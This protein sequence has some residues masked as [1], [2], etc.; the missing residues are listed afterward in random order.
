VILHPLE[1]DQA[2]LR[3]SNLVVQYLELIGD[4]EARYLGV[5]QLLDRLPD[6]LLNLT[7]AN[8]VGLG[9]YGASYQKF[10]E[11]V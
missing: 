3:G 1:N 8:R 11:E 2:A 10:G 7:N 4:A 6:R 9:A 5:D